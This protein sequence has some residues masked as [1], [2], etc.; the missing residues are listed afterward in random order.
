MHEGISS[1]IFAPLLILQ[2]FL[3][4]IVASLW[5]QGWTDSRRTIELQEVG[6]HLAS[7]TQQ[8]YSSIN[9]FT[10]SSGKTTVKLEIPQFIE[11]IPYIGNATLRQTLSGNSSKILEISLRLTTVDITVSTIATLGQNTVWKDSAF[12][13]NSPPVYLVAEK[14]PDGTIQLG[15]EE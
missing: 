9:R 7:S 11:S 8:L 5:L 13:S 14:Y 2:I 6:S 12:Q 1:V 10:V 15:F 4:P 3:F